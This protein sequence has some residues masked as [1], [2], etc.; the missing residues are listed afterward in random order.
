MRIDEKTVG[1]FTA[2]EIIAH[3]FVEMTFISFEEN[4]IQ[5]EFLKINTIADVL[6]TGT[7]Q[8]LSDTKS[9]EDLIQELSEEE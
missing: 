4:K 1:Q 2:L 8:K 9:L 6:R 3:C 5:K 7:H